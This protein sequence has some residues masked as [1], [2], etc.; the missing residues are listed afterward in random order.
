MKKDRLLNNKGFT[1][2]ELIIVFAITA[3]M[4]LFIGLTI[5]MVNGSNVNKAARSCEHA[6]VQ[7]RVQSMAKGTENGKVYIWD[8]GGDVYIKVGEQGEAELLCDD[9]IKAYFVVYSP[10]TSVVSGK[11]EISAIS[12]DKTNA[13]CMMFTNIG[14]VSKV[15]PSLGK[16]YN[17]VLFERGTRQTVVYI[18]PET[19]KIS[20]VTL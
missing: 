9:R 17:A 20:V 16:T 1:L 14:T 6:L 2:L 12:P 3:I 15:D 5:G 19:G 4:V 7:G 13:K 11:T 8:V 10:A 18:Y